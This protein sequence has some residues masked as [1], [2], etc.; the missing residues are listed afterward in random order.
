MFGEP[1]PLTRECAQA[2]RH[3]NRLFEEA[4]E[5]ASRWTITFAKP[6][7]PMVIDDT[8]PEVQAWLVKALNCPRC[9]GFPDGHCLACG[10][11]NSS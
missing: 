3:I 11:S 8:P 6:V 5:R 7:E 10:C 1:D 9:Y 4:K 2:R